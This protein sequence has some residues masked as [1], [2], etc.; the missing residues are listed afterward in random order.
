MK[1]MQNQDLE[2]EQLASSNHA[3]WL[4]FHAALIERRVTS[5]LTQREVAQRLGISQPAVSQ[6]ENLLV[7]PNLESVLGYALAIG[8]E[9]DFSLRG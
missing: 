6:F 2:I 4:E 1:L 3:S 7:L 8:A 9:V 5:G